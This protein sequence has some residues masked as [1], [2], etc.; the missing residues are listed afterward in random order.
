MTIPV[1]L[2]K[3][4]VLKWNWKLESGNID[5][6]NKFGDSEL[7]KGDRVSSHQG[8]YVANEDGVFSFFFDNSFSWVNGKVVCGSASIGN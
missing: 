8:E 3:G 5:V 6:T 7:Y 4:D 1:E 2:K